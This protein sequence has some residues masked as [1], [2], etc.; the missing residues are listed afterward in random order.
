MFEGSAEL[1]FPLFGDRLRGAAFVDFGQAWSRVEDFG[2][3]RLVWT[4]GFGVRYFTPIGPIR[5]D[6][7]Y[8]PGHA[9]SVRVITTDVCEQT[10]TGCVP[11]GPDGPSDPS[12][13]RNTSRLRLLD[14]AIP[15][16]PNPRDELLRRFQLHLS[17][18]QAF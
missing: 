14:R 6:L 13:L 2:S 8:N 7:G 12:K 5:V 17:I 4:P 1:R 15:W 11:I 9:E 10:A 16:D 18:G 3:G